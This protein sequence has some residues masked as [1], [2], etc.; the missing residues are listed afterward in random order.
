[1]DTSPAPADEIVEPTVTSRRRGSLLLLRTAG[2]VLAVV[3]VVMHVFAP[4]MSAGFPHLST[5]G[6]TLITAGYLTYFDFIFPSTG[7]GGWEAAITNTLSP[8]DKVLA[9]R[10]G[11]FSHRWIDMCRRHGLDVQVVETAWGEGIPRDAI[12]AILTADK[13]HEIK[14]VLATPQRDGDRR[15]LATS[16]RSAGR[17]TP[18]GTPR[19]CSSTACRSIGSMDFRLDDWGVDVAVTGTQKGFML[20]A[21]LAIVGF[22]REG[23]WRR[24]DRAAAA[25]LLRRARHGEGYANNGFPYTPPVGLLNGLTLS[26]EM[27]L[28]EGL[29]NVFARHERIA[30]GVR[31]RGRRPGG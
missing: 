2:W 18:P 19:C 20:P 5:F 30:D 1:M 11:M 22:C 10:N 12:E 23:A 13:G 8:G 16:R 29:D 27:L 25:L 21:G 4:A 14:A 28:D 15:A 31:A 6:W 9:A 24:R 3:V 26:C 17:W 7:T